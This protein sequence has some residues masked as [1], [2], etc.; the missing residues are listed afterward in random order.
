MSTASLPSRPSARRVSVVVVTL[1]LLLSLIT[2]VSAHAAPVALDSTIAKSAVGDL[3]RLTLPEGAL[4]RRTPEAAEKFQVCARVV[5]K[6]IAVADHTAPAPKT[7]PDDRSGNT[8]LSDAAFAG[9]VTQ[10]KAMLAEI[11]STA[12][13]RSF[14]ANLAD[15]RIPG[16]DLG[17]VDVTGPSAIESDITVLIM[18]TRVPGAFRTVPLFPADAKD[19]TASVLTFD[20]EHVY[21]MWAGITTDGSG[22]RAR[23]RALDA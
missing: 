16:T 5:A 4:D 22:G 8:A 1:S 23:A 19:G 10:T 18:P 7:H 20:F 15:V 3:R 21:G 9:Y 12:A 17:F 11:S 13:G 6:G 14:L 2:P